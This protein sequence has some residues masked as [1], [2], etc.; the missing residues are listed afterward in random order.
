VS[1]PNKRKINKGSSD[2]LTLIFQNNAST[3]LSLYQGT[4]GFAS[5]V[6]LTILP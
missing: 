6:N 4:A 3:N 5:G 1:D 2:V